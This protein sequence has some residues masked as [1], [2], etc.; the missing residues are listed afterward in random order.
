[1]VLIIF[2]LEERLRLEGNFFVV[3]VERLRLEGSL[4]L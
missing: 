3:V 4:E 1:M 2:E